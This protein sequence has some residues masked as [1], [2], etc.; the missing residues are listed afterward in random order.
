MYECEVVAYM[1]KDGCLS[2]RLKKYLVMFCWHF[3]NWQKK[4]VN[5][6]HVWVD[7]V[8][9]EYNWMPIR[10]KNIHM[11]HCFVLFE[12]WYFFSLLFYPVPNWIKMTICALRQQRVYLT[13]W[14]KGTVVKGHSKGQNFKVVFSFNYSWIHW[15]RATSIQVYRIIIFFKPGLFFLLLERD[16]TGE[17][18]DKKQF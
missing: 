11:L 1:W 13:L 17:R 15:T 10:D 9:L 6:C 5:G 12:R 4:C 7:P 2:V 18:D 16:A 8:T 3:L 14:H